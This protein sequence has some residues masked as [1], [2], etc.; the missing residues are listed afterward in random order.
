MVQ[1]VRQDK[2]GK[3]WSEGETWVEQKKDTN[4]ARVNKTHDVW[5]TAGDR[6]EI[7]SEFPG[8]GNKE[9][10]ILEYGTCRAEK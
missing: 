8:S 6:W 2:E 7:S 4:N 3:K 9:A 10:S 5:V 1:C